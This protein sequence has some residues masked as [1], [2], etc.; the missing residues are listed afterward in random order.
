M[1]LRLMLSLPKMKSCTVLDRN[2]AFLR[3]TFW[4]LGQLVGTLTKTIFCAF[5]ANARGADCCGGRLVLP[6]RTK[7]R[8]LWYSHRAALLISS[9]SRIGLLNGRHL[10]FGRIASALTTP[11]WS[12]CGSV[13]L[14]LSESRPRTRVAMA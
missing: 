13:A 6:D 7:T 10:P 5:L 11:V 8:S 14:R 9:K 1:T 3:H 4:H 2:R 12:G